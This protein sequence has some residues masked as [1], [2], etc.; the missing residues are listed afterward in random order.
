MADP[1][2]W[3]SQEKAKQ[4]VEK[5]KIL[6][7]VYEPWKKADDDTR[8]TLEL[9]EMV[10]ENQPES[11]QDIKQE[12]DR[13]AKEVAAVEFQRLLSDPRDARN[14]IVNINAGAGG[15]EACDWTSILLRQY[16]QVCTDNEFGSLKNILTVLQNF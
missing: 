9:I 15:T 6:K 1:S 2:F 11:F 13:L 8:D 3:N 14:A 5:I 12:V 16:L 7:N 4:T 10:D